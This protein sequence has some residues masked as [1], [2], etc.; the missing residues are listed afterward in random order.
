MRLK[1]I[2]SRRIVGTRTNEDGSLRRIYD[3]TYDDLAYD[4]VSTRASTGTRVESLL[5]ERYHDYIE[6]PEPVKPTNGELVRK[7]YSESLRQEL[8]RKVDTMYRPNA[9]LA[10]LQAN[11]HNNILLP[12]AADMLCP[13]CG[14]T[15]GCRCHMFDSR[16]VRILC[17]GSPP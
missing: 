3:R 13:K 11:S 2:K 1:D 5:V 9:K 15:L 6:A 10:Y 14:M 4:H 17:E 8:V 7:Y 16:G 12:A